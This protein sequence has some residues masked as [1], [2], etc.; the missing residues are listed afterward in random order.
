MDKA[1]K[2]GTDSKLIEKDEGLEEVVNL[3]ASFI[4]R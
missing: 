3:W 1:N 4:P 2:S